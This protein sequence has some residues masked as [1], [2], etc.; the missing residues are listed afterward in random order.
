MRN[1]VAVVVS[2]W[3]RRQEARCLISRQ[4]ETETKPDAAGAT[5]F[6]IELPVEFHVKEAEQLMDQLLDAPDDKKPLSSMQSRS[7]P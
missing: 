6:V 7:K 3:K 2:T 5:D 1:A 4:K